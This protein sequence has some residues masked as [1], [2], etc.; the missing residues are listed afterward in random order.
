MYMHMYLLG[1]YNSDICN[2]FITYVMWYIYLKGFGN[3]CVLYVHNLRNEST[4]L[5]Y[6]HYSKHNEF[7]TLNLLNKLMK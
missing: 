4:N 2:Q 5:I 6:V 3:F 7:G 1:T